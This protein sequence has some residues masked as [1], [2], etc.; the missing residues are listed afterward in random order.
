VITGRCVAPVTPRERRGV[1]SRVPGRIPIVSRL[2]FQCQQS[3]ASC[4]FLRNTWPFQ[5]TQQRGNFREHVLSSSPGFHH[6]KLP[7]GK[8]CTSSEDVPAMSGILHPVLVNSEK[9]VVFG[10]YTKAGFLRDHV[11]LQHCT[12]HAPGLEAFFL[13]GNHNTCARYA[14]TPAHLHPR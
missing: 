11:C 2:V 10:L 7:V 13:P 9:S 3:G 14:D 1:P 4:G 8:L 6:I 5:P 12:R